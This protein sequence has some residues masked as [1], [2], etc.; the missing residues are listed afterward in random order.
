MADTSKTICSQYSATIRTWKRTERYDPGHWFPLMEGNWN[1]S[2]RYKLWYTNSNPGLP[3][4]MI[5]FAFIVVY[6][7]PIYKESLAL[8]SSSS[9]WFVKQQTSKFESWGS[10]RTMNDQWFNWLMCYSNKSAKLYIYWMFLE[11]CPWFF[12]HVLF[13][14]QL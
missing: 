1:T 8:V 9:L 10:F 6:W 2:K 14:T 5:T 12:P 13:K 4:K 7:I 11:W 3:E